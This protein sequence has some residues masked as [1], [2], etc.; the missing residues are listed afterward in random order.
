M[1]NVCIYYFKKM[2]AQIGEKEAK[3][4]LSDLSGNYLM[5]MLKNLD[6]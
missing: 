4:L 6:K 2:L 5:Q 3:S 1:F